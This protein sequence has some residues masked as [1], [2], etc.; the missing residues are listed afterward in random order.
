MDFIDTHCHIHEA[1]HTPSHLYDGYP[2]A[3][4]DLMLS[5]ARSIGV[6][7][8]ICVGTTLADSR[9]AVDF[10][11]AKEGVWS[12]VGL[13]PHE[14][15]VYFNGSSLKK[16]VIEEFTSLVTMSKV[17]AVGECGLDY[18]YNHSPKSQQI[19]ILRFQI[20]LA[21]DHDLPIIFHVREAFVDFWP[22]LNDYPNIKGVL[23]SFTD[24]SE[25]LSLALDRGL[26]IGVNGIATFAKTQDRLEIYR[27]IPLESLL[28]ETDSPFLTPTPY[29]GRM[30]EPKYVRLVAEYLS[31]IRGEDLNTLASVT[32]KNA[33][34][35][36][37]ME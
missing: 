31:A 8:V 32:T 13:H 28:L 22:I 18:H 36:F 17:V 2:S 1:L 12:A 25:N 7:K 23:H 33:L 6:T 35:L 3:K 20:E 34:K 14:A 29:R 21:I 30:N 19:D 9:L 26:L 24:S 15:K 4:P 10:A 37:K 5:A 27:S 16:N 11:Q